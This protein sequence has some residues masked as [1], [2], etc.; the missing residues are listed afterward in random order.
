MSLLMILWDSKLMKITRMAGYTSGI[1]ICHGCTR[2]HGWKMEHGAYIIGNSLHYQDY[3]WYDALKDSKL[4]EEALHNKAIIEGRIDDNDELRPR[5]KEID[6]GA[7]SFPILLQQDLL[8][9]F[10]DVGEVSTISKSGS[11]RVLKLQ[12]GCS[13]RILVT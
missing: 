1:K 6:D 3:E 10:Y 2:N 8:K 11:V 12:D 7:C 9:R 5:C 4:K 13:T